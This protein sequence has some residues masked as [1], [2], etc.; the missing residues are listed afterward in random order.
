MVLIWSLSFPQDECGQFP[1][2]ANIQ[3]HWVSFL[4]G[5]QRVLLFTDDVALVSKALQAEEMEQANHEITFSLHSLGLSLVNNENKQEVSYIGITRYERRIRYQ[6]SWKGIEFVISGLMSIDRYLFWICL[7]CN[8]FSKTY[9][10]TVFTASWKAPRI[11]R[12]LRSCLCPYNTHQL[13][14]GEGGLLLSLLFV[15][16]FLE[17]IIKTPG[18]ATK[19]YVHVQWCCR[20]WRNW[21]GWGVPTTSCVHR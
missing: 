6:K 16:T 1:Y 7:L 10:T 5:R 18:K 9:W 4:D 17:R 19:K 20:G 2:D 3:I 15:C 11:E 8:S 21:C 14:G 12:W 13:A